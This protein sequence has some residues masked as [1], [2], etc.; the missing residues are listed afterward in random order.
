MKVLDHCFSSAIL[1]ALESAQHA[2]LMIASLCVTTLAESINI[3]M[4]ILYL[5]S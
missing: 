2:G 5:N 1:R 3:G 4:N